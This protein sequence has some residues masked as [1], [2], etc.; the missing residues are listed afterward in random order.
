MGGFAVN[1]E[2]IHNKLKRATLT[3]N[4][5]IL[6]AEE[7]HFVTVIPES[8]S[9]K[10]KSNL[11]AKAL[12]CLQILWAAG[13]AI[14]RKAAGFPITLLE[15]HTLVHCFCALVMYVLW[16]RK[17]YDIQ[18]PTIVPT[19]NFPD[20][21]AFIVGSST[22]PGN[23]GFV[24]TRTDSRSET[25]Q[26]RFRSIQDPPIF[27]SG[28]LEDNENSE[29]IKTIP[30]HP[31]PNDAP[32][33]I[34]DP[35]IRNWCLRV[36]EV[37]KE[38]GQ[39]NCADN[40]GLQNSQLPL[41]Y[42][43]QYPVTRIFSPVCNIESVLFL[44]SGQALRSGLG[45]WSLTP[46]DY[47]KN[48]EQMCQMRGYRLGLSG[49]DVLRLDLAGNFIRK[50]VEDPGGN[51]KIRNGFLDVSQNGKEATRTVRYFS[52][53]DSTPHGQLVDCRIHNWVGLD[54]LSA[55]LNGGSY[56]A[57]LVAMILI[58]AAYGGIHWAAIGEMF[59]SK[60]ELILWKSSCIVLLGSAAVCLVVLAI[61]FLLLPY[62]EYRLN[63]MF[64]KNFTRYEFW[65]AL[66]PPAIALSKKIRV[67]GIVIIGP[68]YVAARLFLVIESFIS[69]R[70]VPD[71]VYQTPD[72][73]FFNYVPHL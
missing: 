26:S 62:L 7:G 46:T 45:A 63:I 17:P 35:K 6:L 66:M 50:H 51:P 1:I 71:G 47:Q 31:D 14:E 30:Y 21:L 19:D 38:E 36:K 61:Q 48:G 70:H 56:L 27:W 68:V 43:S 22:W 2:H 39:M 49:K 55:M 18:D 40:D 10:S 57:I 41:T 9:D 20:L 65:D 59:P 28:N 33:E 72:I 11:L 58:P 25:F 53:S 69:L 5:L 29:E 67:V 37:G 13:Q 64:E 42:Y 4:A 52:G 60:V 15:Y 73:N 12:S 3:K 23:S 8:I 16:L 32:L 54:E 44:S 24:S 34:V